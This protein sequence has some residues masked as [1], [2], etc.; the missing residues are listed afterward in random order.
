M[1]IWL[2]MGHSTVLVNLVEAKIAGTYGSSPNGSFPSRVPGLRMEDAFTTKAFGTRLWLFS[3]CNWAGWSRNA[4]R[5]WSV[6]SLFQG[7][8]K[9]DTWSVED[10]QSS[11]QTSRPLKIHGITLQRG[12]EICRFLHPRP[13]CWKNHEQIKKWI[14]NLDDICWFSPAD[15]SAF[16]MATTGWAVTTGTIP[17]RH[18]SWLEFW[19]SLDKLGLDTICYYMLW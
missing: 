18:N 1:W 12:I 8:F 7:G 3:T 14:P 10:V 2:D 6:W 15:I 5:V 4:L 17:G 19:E 11:L 9:P 13:K 16:A